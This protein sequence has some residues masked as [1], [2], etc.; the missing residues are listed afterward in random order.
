MEYFFICLSRNWLLMWADFPTGFS[1]VAVMTENL[2]FGG[3]YS[4]LSNDMFLS[5]HEVL[6]RGDVRCHPY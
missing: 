3:S 1:H 5:H 6:V 2:E 4:L